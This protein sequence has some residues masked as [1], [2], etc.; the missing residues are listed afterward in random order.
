MTEEITK[1]QAIIEPEV[2]VEAEVKE[3]PKLPPGTKAPVRFADGS[4]KEFVFIGEIPENPE[5]KAVAR[6][7]GIDPVSSEAKSYQNEIAD[8]TK[9]VYEWLQ[10]DDSIQISRFI[11]QQLRRTPSNGSRIL[12]LKRQL[13][14]LIEDQKGKKWSK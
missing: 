4:Y 8:I 9:M 7:M 2:K 12:N 6:D 14:L 3:E 1:E 11:R 13:Q 10:T 5:F